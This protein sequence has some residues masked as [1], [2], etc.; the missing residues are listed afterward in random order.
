[1]SVFVSAT[2]ICGIL[3][4]NIPP[5]LHEEIYSMIEDGALDC[6]R[7]WYDADLLDCIVGIEIECLGLDLIQIRD[8]ISRAEATLPTIFHTH[9]LPYK[10]YVTPD[11]F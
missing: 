10:L 9:R 5:E 4:S 8:K 3:Y 6:P 11:V 1:M 7:P 2:L